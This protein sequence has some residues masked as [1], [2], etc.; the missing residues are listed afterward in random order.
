MHSLPSRWLFTVLLCLG[1]A[2]GGCVNQT[3]KSTSVPALE[4]PAA[5]IPEQELLDVAVAV[6]DPGIDEAIDENPDQRIYPEVRRAEAHFIP[7]LLTETLQNTGAWGAVR[8]VPDADRISD[9][10]VTGQIRHSDG[11]ALVVH[12][13]ARDASGVIWLDRSYQAHASRYAYDARTRMSYDPFQA[14]YHEVANDLL[15]KLREH[16][17]EE[18]R[19]LRTIAELRF[20]RNFSEE[21]FASYLEEGEEGVEIAR[22]PARDDPMLQ[23]VR[24][25]RDRDHLFVDTL[26]GHY[27]EFR[28]GMMPAYQEWRKLSYEEVIALDELRARSRR[29][30]I[31][32]GISVLAGIAGATGGDSATTRA[33][34]SVAMIGGGYLI[35]SG[36]ETR[37]E[38]Q[39]HV[40]SL[41]ELGLSL[42][43]E[44]TPQVI[45]LEDRSVMLSG[46]VEQQYAQ[47]RDLLAEIYQREVGDL[48]SLPPEDA[49]GGEPRSAATR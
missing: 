2:L 16:P 12:I 4:R 22:L 32:G 48:D 18:R 45:E 44:V 30:L 36:L 15:G 46:S 7:Q 14:L 43:A 47:W 37:N 5:P 27:A 1:A 34:G 3:V 29:Q 20:A 23:R 13:T 35:K 19:D 8:V 17:P 39:I 42:E 26:Q 11:E 10:M 31:A 40:E 28:D 38:A 9:L 21:A 33:A 41:E 6:F 25:I 24:K 49:Q